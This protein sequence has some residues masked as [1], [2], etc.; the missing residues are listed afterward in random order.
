MKVA[1]FDIDGTILVA[2]GAGRRAM[3]RALLAAVGT[4]G[5]GGQHYA[6]KTDPQIAREAMRHAGLTD[7]EIDARMAGVLADYLGHLEAELAARGDEPPA[8]LPGIV[9]LLDACEAHDS[10][11]LGLLTGNLVVG[12]ERKLRAVGVDPGRFEVGAFG[13][14]HEDRPA[15][16]AIARERA[17]TYLERQVPGEACVVIGD[18]PADVAC[19]LAIGARTIAVAT[20]TFSA[21]ALRDAGA[22]VVFDHLG[23]TSAAMEAILRG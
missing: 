15:L 3:E 19:G 1:L 22:H 5:P 9:A 16:A 10:V 23:D 7:A 21:A 8:L 20:G 14:D 6:G 2:H 12:A 18:T 17:A 13:S 4:T 11:V